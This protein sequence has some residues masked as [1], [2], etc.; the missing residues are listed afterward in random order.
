MFRGFGQKA[1]TVAC[2][3]PKK[4]M[5]SV[6]SSDF[7]ELRTF[8]NNSPVCHH[9][10]KKERTTMD[11]AN[12]KRFA[13]PPRE[14]SPSRTEAG[15]LSRFLIEAFART[16]SGTKANQKRTKSEL[17]SQTLAGQQLQVNQK[18][19][20]SESNPNR[21]RNDSESSAQNLQKHPQNMRNG[22]PKNRRAPCCLL[23]IF[24]WRIF[25]GII[26]LLW[27]PKLFVGFTGFWIQTRELYAAG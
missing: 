9:G 15:V 13:V 21:K 23:P 14:K 16:K 5:L 8:R 18:W 26:S 27:K 25:R 22:S 10:V 6:R 11:I 3:K 4:E 1:R 20:E 17:F 2:R 19:H 24:D 12:V 7:S